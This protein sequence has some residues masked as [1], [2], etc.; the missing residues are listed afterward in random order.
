MG[1]FPDRRNAAFDQ[2]PVVFERQQIFLLGGDQFRGVDFHQRVSLPDLIADEVDVKLFDPAGD[3]G[4][5]Q[6]ET[7]LV[8][9]DLADGADRAGKV[10]LPGVIGAYTHVLYGRRV[11]G[12]HTARFHSCFVLVDGDQIHAHLRL[13]GP[14]VHLRRVH[15]RLPVKDFALGGGLLLCC[16]ILV[17]RDE[18]H[19]HF[20]LAGP[21]VH[22][23]RVHRRLPV[24]DLALA[25]GDGHLVPSYG[26]RSVRGDAPEKK[27]PGSKRRKQQRDPEPF[28]ES[29]YVH[30]IQRSGWMPD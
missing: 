26:C 20:R 19:T 10:H 8:V 29:L 9:P 18:I 24:E 1:V 6:I 14:V 5:D 22:L 28:D 2:H 25:F 21:V 16:F 3:L 15:R 27:T 13:A 12:H 7:L 4:V 23:R 17:N 11:D 30:G